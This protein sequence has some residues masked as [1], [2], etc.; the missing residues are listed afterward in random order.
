MGNRTNHQKI[1]F[2]AN[3]ATITMAARGPG[4]LYHGKSASWGMSVSPYTR[5]CKSEAGLGCD[6]RLTKIVTRKQ[7]DHAKMA[8]QKFCAMV[9]GKVCSTF[10]SQPPL[11]SAT[12]S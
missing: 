5:L 11:F 2:K 3:S 7:A 9:D 12:V 1:K 10:P 6:A 8:I 4:R